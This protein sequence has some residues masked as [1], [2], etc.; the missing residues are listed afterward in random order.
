MVEKGQLPFDINPTSPLIR[1]EGVMNGE[2][3]TYPTDQKYHDLSI[4][5]Q[6]LIDLT[7]QHP[8]SSSDRP[9]S[10]DCTA[11]KN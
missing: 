8:S 9:P 3:I 10:F 4:I 6:A 1:V 2:Q 7:R 11:E 5:S